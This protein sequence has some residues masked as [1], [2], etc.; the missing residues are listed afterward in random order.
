MR[1][2]S[3]DQF[4][5]VLARKAKQKKVLARATFDITYKCNHRCTYCYV[6]EDKS[7]EEIKTKDVL[8]ILDS[9]ARTGCLE[10]SFSGGELFLR[11]D[12]FEILAYAKKK[13]FTINIMTNGSLIDERAADFLKGI[14]P[15]KVDITVLGAHQQTF[16]RVTGVKG[17]FEK[18]IKGIERLVKRGVVVDVK[19]MVLKENMHEFLKM[20]HLFEGMGV[21]QFLSSYILYPAYDGD[22]KPLRHRLSQ[23]ELQDYWPQI[24]AKGIVSLE[25]DLDDIFRSCSGG[26]ETCSINS[27]GDM[28]I[29]SAMPAP[30]YNILED[31][32]EQCWRKL[33][34]FVECYKPSDNYKCRG[35]GLSNY[36]DFCPAMSLLEEGDC[37]SCSVFKREIAEVKLTHKRNSKE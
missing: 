19:C 20:K 3:Y 6:R 36:C 33:V 18:V 11:P 34:N 24:G 17:S 23:E 22:R 8:S 26:K 29:C 31:G 1:Q 30:K 5:N 9:L 16:E 25:G 2:V 32:F 10:L 4:V 37:S 28:L 12:I 35:C 27:Y 14:V 13:G 21:R 7:R 15:Y